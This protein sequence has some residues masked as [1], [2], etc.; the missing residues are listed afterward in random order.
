LLSATCAFLAGGGGG[1]GGGTTANADSAGLAFNCFT[2]SAVETGG[3][4]SKAGFPSTA[5]DLFTFSGV[6][7][8]AAKGALL[9]SS[10]LCGVNLGTRLLDNLFAHFYHTKKKLKK[11]DTPTVTTL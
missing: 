10:P 9:I 3:G 11:C 6:E 7:T 4:D 5:F 1:G 2:F 8:A